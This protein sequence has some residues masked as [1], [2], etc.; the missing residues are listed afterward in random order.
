MDL[1]GAEARKCCAEEGQQQFN[2]QSSETGSVQTSR[3]TSAGQRERAAASGG[4]TWLGSQSMARRC[5][6]EIVG[7]QYR[8]E[9]GS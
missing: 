4:Q 5:G 9:H 2:R 7:S 3:V 8:H 6:Y 1:E